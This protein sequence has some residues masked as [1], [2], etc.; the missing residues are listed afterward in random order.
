MHIQIIGRSTNDPAGPGTVGA[1]DGKQA[2]SEPEIEAIRS[3]AR[4]FLQ[5]VG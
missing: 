1:F 3:D 5:I 4:T 2:Y